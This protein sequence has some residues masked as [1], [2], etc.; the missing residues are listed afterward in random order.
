MVQKQRMEEFE[1]PGERESLDRWCVFVCSQYEQVCEHT[2]AGSIASV[3]TARRNARLPACGTIGQLCQFRFVRI[4]ERMLLSFFCTHIYKVAIYYTKE[5]IGK[6]GTIGIELIATNRG[7]WWR[8][9]GR[10]GYTFM[11]CG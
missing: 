2:P 8:F 7:K 4:I 11:G 9:Y 1:P 5:Q 10:M 3:G 6:Y